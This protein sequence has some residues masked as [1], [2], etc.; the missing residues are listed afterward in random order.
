DRMFSETLFKSILSEMYDEIVH[1]NK[2]VIKLTLNVSNFSTQ[3][4]KTF[5]LMNIDE[6]IDNHTLSIEIQKL[7]E[8]FG[9][10]IIKTADEL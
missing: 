7:R 9:L 6:D 1:L 8:R 4:K 10:D 5:S 2:S 3:H